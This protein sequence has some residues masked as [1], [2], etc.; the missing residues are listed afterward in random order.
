MEKKSFNIVCLIF[1]LYVHA[2]GQSAFDE[3]L[4]SMYRNTVPLVTVEVLQNNLGKNKNMILLD[5]RTPVEY[6][7]SH[8]PHAKFIDYRNFKLHKLD[9]LSRQTLIVVY[10]SVG[11]RS[12]RV[13]EQ[14]FA[15]GFKNVKNLYGGIFE[16]VNK[17]YAI[18]DGFGKTTTRVHTY[19]KNWSRWLKRGIKIY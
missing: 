3:K 15:M 14:L 9:T 1:A 11:Y 5:I 12:E 17:G 18:V 16:W 4:Q 19:N 6:A 10:C 8:L 7:V 13:G 2:S